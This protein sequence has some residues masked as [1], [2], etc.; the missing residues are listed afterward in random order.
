MPGQKTTKFKISSSLKPSQAPKKPLESGE[1]KQQKQPANTQTIRIGS[2]KD[3]PTEGHYGQDGPNTGS[4][5]VNKGPKQ[6]VVQYAP[7]KQLEGNNRV[8]EKNMQKVD[9]NSSNAAKELNKTTIRLMEEELELIE[10]QVRDKKSLLKDQQSLTEKYSQQREIF[11]RSD[12]ALAERVE[13][14][15]QENQNLETL[16]TG[17]KQYFIDVCRKKE[18]LEATLAHLGTFD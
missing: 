6:P 15:R 16:S 14:M 12:S 10:T 18:T 1:S 8:Q 3:P 9:G 11:D 7:M 17:M 13:L 2:R 5:S 4:N